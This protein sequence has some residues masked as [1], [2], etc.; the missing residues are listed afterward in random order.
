MC[1]Y[2]MNLM[3]WVLWK[4]ETILIANIQLRLGFLSVGF[5][6]SIFL[7]R[8]PRAPGPALRMDTNLLAR[9]CTSLSHT[10]RRYIVVVNN[11]LRSRW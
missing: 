7:I 5:T 10:L 4:L 9:R 1:L 3:K 2:Q 6:Y 8:P 11:Y